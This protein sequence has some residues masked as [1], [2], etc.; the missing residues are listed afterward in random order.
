MYYP[1][2]IRE[3]TPAS[4]EADT[5]PRTAE[6]SQDSVTNTPTPLDKP[7]EETDHLGVSEK[8]K[9]INQE[10]IQDVMKPPADPQAP[11][12]KNEAP[13]KMELVLASLVVPIQAVPPPSQ[14]SEASGTASQQL[15]KDKLT[16]KLKK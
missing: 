1:L 6:A 5:A 14:G 12:A 16:I 4:Y 2:A 13:K 8:D 10:T 11:V 15:P 3:S 9:T 7:A